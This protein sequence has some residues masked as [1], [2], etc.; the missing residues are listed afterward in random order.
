MP[1][2]EATDHDGLGSLPNISDNSEAA[3]VKPMV[4]SFASHPE[5]RRGKSAEEKLMR[6]K[7]KHLF[8]DTDPCERFCRKHCK[9]LTRENHFTTWNSF[10]EEQ[11]ESRLKWLAS[12]VRLAPVNRRTVK[13]IKQK[14]KKNGSRHYFLPKVVQHLLRNP[15]VQ[16]NFTNTRW[17]EN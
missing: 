10:R 6:D 12:C 5:R 14:F 9:E 2:T 4:P 17:L 15:S 1:L 13:F 8:I 3:A 16:K 7:E 11:Y